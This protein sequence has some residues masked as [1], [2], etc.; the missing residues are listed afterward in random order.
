M[1]AEHDAIDVRRQAAL[2]REI[3]CGVSRRRNQLQ[4]QPVTNEQ[5]DGNRHLSSEPG[6]QKND[7]RKEVTDGDTLQDT[8]NL[9]LCKSEIRKAIDKQ[10]DRENGEGALDDF[11]VEVPLAAASLETFSERERNGHADD[12]K[13]EW[14][15]EIGWRP[16]VPG[17]VLEWSINEFPCAGIVYQ[18]HT[19]D[20]DAAKNVERH[21]AVALTR[22]RGCWHRRR[23]IAQSGFG[24]RNIMTKRAVP[25]IHVPDVR[26]TV[27]WY[28]EI[29]F[30][31]VATYADETGD[32]LSFAIVSYGDSQVM[33]SEGGQTKHEASPRSRSLR[34]HR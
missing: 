31:V 17:C 25:M 21:E 4:R 10:A 22:N 23:I 33:F 16:A 12:E 20:R 26:A 14:E 19:G 2:L 15:N 8:G 6:I 28:K 9:I 32:E 13:K 18:D 3:T 30:E 34:L 11:R 24:G 5:R 7:R 29:G 27:D 1:L